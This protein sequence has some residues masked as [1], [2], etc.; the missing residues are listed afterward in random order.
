MKVA[1]CT[2][3]QQFRANRIL[4][5]SWAKNFPGALWVSFFADF[6]KKKGVEVVTGDVALANIQVKHWKPKDILVV[7]ALDAEYGK[8]LV[9][10]GAK[11]FILTGF[12]SPLH[13]PYFYDQLPKIALQFTHRILY[14]GAFKSFSIRKGFNHLAYFPSFIRN[15][16]IRVKKWD[17]RKFIVMVAANKYFEKPFP[18]P[19]PH[20]LS[21][22][23]DWMRD[24]FAKWQSQTR[25]L[26]IESELITKRLGAIEYFDSAEKINLFG[27]DWDNI[28]NLPFSWQK[29][30]GK[31]IK[32]L[33]PKLVENKLETIS[34]YKFS[35]CFEN[36]SYPGFISE[37]II[38]CFVA[39][40]IPIYLGA[41]N[42]EK[43]VPPNSFIDMRNFDS[44]EKLH[45]YLIKVDN[46]KASKMIQMG[47]NF[48]ESNKGKFYNQEEFAKFVSK[49]VLNLRF[50]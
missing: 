39:G 11:P 31:I 26:A 42:I 28:Q 5:K 4:D 50:S 35:I 41:P 46:N 36:V 24:R 18:I 3:E 38:D 9:K 7:Q 2:N 25:T 44:W 20:Y 14:S 19:I 43:F 16:I 8:Q 29:R 27:H 22:Y 34:F 45:K 23:F 13:A 37:K 10:L 17:G 6:L 1:I 21:E 32:R 49:L 48:L 15:D 12:E 40:V 30:L 33:K 47:R